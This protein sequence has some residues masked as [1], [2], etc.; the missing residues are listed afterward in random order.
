ME[1]KFGEGSPDIHLDAEQTCD[2]AGL[3]QN[4]LP[5]PIDK[6]TLWVKGFSRLMG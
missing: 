6:G 5:P 1:M 3:S 2:V 4:F